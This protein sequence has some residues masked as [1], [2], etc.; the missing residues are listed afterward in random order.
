MV[1]QIGKYIL[2]GLCL[3]VIFIFFSRIKVDFT[4]KYF[5]PFGL[6]MLLIVFIIHN[7]FTSKN[8]VKK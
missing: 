8:E 3:G 1:K 5:V 4:P 2:L 7:I 6:S